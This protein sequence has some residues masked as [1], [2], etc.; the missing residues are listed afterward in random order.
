M[1][2][3]KPAALGLSLSLA[4]LPSACGKGSPG[5]SPV[6]AAPAASSSDAAAVVD[7]GPTD[8]PGRSRAFAEKLGRHEFLDATGDLGGELAQK[9]P[10]NRLALLWQEQTSR[11]G[12]FVKV[13]AVEAKSPD[14]QARLAFAHGTATLVLRFDQDGQKVTRFSLTS[15]PAPYA[16][17]AYVDA[18]KFTSTEV[19]IGDGPAALPA[20][21]TVPNGKGPFH[22][23]L[24]V[25]DAGEQD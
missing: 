4:L 21:L 2:L 9:L 18:T 1:S 10:V 11:L 12:R 14:L 8:P 23:L 15:A 20:T 6:D 24:L 17:P 25:P 19:A 16:P 22:A 7:A 3:L 13:D 5:V